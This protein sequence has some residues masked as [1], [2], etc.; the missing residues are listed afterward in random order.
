MATDQFAAFLEAADPVAAHSRL[1]G[2]ELRAQMQSNT[3]I[4][5]SSSDDGNST[6]DTIADLKL[7]VFLR[8][9]G[10]MSPTNRASASAIPRGDHLELIAPASIWEV[11]PG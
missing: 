11:L 10:L 9:G 8:T 6:D 5:L 3:W 4:S 2:A 7:Q 1:L